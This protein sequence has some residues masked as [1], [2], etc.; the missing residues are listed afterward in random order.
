MRLLGRSAAIYDGRAMSG[1]MGKQGAQTH[2]VVLSATAEGDGSVVTLSTTTHTVITEGLCSHNTDLPFSAARMSRLR[3]WARIEDWRWQMI[4]PQLCDPVWRWA[5]EAAT[6]AGLVG[7][8]WSGAEW[9]APPLPMID[10]AAEG[11]AYQRNVRAGIMS[12]SE[13]LRERGYDPEA[14]LEELADDFERLDK[15]G[16]VLD[17]DPRQMTQAGQAQAAPAAP[18]SVEEDT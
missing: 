6:I 17:V 13:A 10:P 15:L 18:A 8:G 9:T 1:G 4:I 11:L 7:E 2:A 16:L 14:T 3:Q 5:M 12:L